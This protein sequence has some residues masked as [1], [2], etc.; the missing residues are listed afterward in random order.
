MTQVQDEPKS[1]QTRQTEMGRSPTTQD[2]N[3]SRILDSS[4]RIGYKAVTTPVWFYHHDTPVSNTHSYYLNIK[5]K[6]ANNA[7]LS[8]DDT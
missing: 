2:L 1:R 4:S 6:Y 3:I 5:S 8:G 7:N